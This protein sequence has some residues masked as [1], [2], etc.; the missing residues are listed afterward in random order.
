M[1]CEN[2]GKQNPDGAAFCE[3]CGTSMAAVVQEAPKKKKTGLIIGIVSFVLVAAVVAALFIFGVFKPGSVKAA[4]KFWNAYIK[5]DAK[6]AYNLCSPYYRDWAE[7][8]DEKADIIDE[9]KEELESEKEEYDDEGIKRSVEDF[10][11]KKKYTKKEVKL[12][13]EYLEEEEY[14]CD[15]DAHKIQEVHLVEF[16]KV[17]KEDGDKEDEDAE[18][19]MLKIKGKWYIEQRLDKETIKDI[20]KNAD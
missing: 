12:I 9:I 15:A 10:K 1:F 17:E 20:I 8:D 11:A 2:C 16:K 13:E 18:A 19:V 6:T 4:E 7:E 5:A 3:A 14:D